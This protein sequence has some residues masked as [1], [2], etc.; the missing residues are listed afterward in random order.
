MQ[1][2]SLA[3]EILLAQALLLLIFPTLFLWQ[4][5]SLPQMDAASVHPDLTLVY[6]CK[7]LQINAIE[8]GWLK[9]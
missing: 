8:E 3:L 7:L 6:I 2:F 4:Y 1:W 5:S 9:A